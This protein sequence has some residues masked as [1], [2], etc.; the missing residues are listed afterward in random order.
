MET[1][2][3]D[4][5]AGG[6]ILP[7]PLRCGILGESPTLMEALGELGKTSRRRITGHYGDD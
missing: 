6:L 3:T 1:I 4:D 5:I 7:A 2:C